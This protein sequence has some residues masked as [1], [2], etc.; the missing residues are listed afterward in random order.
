MP[1]L[2]P[3]VL[4]LLV[5]AVIVSG[6][7]FT[8]APFIGV[9][10]AGAPRSILDGALQLF[11]FQFI[12]G[13]VLHLLSNMILL[14]LVGPTFE[15]LLGTTRAVV[16]CVI[17]TVLI[18]GSILVFSPSRVVGMSGLLMGILG[19]VSVVYYRAHN[20]EYRSM[21]FFLGLNVV[22]GLG[23]GISFVGHAAGAVVGVVLGLIGSQLNARSSR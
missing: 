5:A 22:L 16:L 21:L 20:P 6:L 7:T 19:Y 1:K 14:V 4:T 23:S 8:V 2:S 9:Y 12:H 3:L 13:G 15:K 11:L 10:A 17:M 18:Y